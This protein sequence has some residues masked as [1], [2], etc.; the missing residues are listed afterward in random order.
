MSIHGQAMEHLDKARALLSSG[1]EDAL[2]YAAL[3]LRYCI[4]HLFYELIPHYRDDLPDNIFSGEVWRPADIIDMITEIDPGVIYDRHVRIGLAPAPGVPGRLTNDLGRQTGLRKELARRIYHGLGFYLHARVDRHPHD[5][6]R[7]RAKLMKTL[8]H[9]ERFEGD[10]IIITGFQMRTTKRCDDCGRAIG[11]RMA[12]IEERPY[13]ACK[14]TKCGAIYNV[15][16]VDGTTAHWK[17][18]QENLKCPKCQADNWLGVH[19]MKRGAQNQSSFNCR[20]CGT[21]Y[22]L[23]DNIM[24][25]EKDPTSAGGGTI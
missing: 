22:Q 19:I 12:D 14:N 15:T 23:F 13:A 2:R 7:L 17:L 8:P 16:R 11:R 21:T 20:G 25:K 4:E 3:E 5:V 10:R 24:V 6:T 9:L 1:A 18:V